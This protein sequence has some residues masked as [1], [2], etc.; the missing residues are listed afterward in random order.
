MR[1]LGIIYPDSVA[2]G[3][4]TSQEERKEIFK[5]L[6]KNWSGLSILEKQGWK[7]KTEAI[8]QSADSSEEQRE[9]KRKKLIKLLKSIVCP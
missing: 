8:N 1:N 6:G 3:N 5:E 9:I 4:A 2:L 7:K